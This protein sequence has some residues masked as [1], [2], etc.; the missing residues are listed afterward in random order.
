MSKYQIFTKLPQISHTHRNR[1]LKRHN[2]KRTN[3]FFPIHPGMCNESTF[4]I[5]ASYEPLNVP[6]TCA[7]NRGVATIGTG[8]VSIPDEKIGKCVEKRTKSTKRQTPGRCFHLTLVKRKGCLRY[9]L[10]WLVSRN[11]YRKMLF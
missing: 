9:R 4:F 6:I 8:G 5:F 2:W 3:C 10:E 1:K 7:L 11:H